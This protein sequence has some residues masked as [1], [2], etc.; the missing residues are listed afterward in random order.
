MGTELKL[1]GYSKDYHYVGKIEGLFIATEQEIDDFLVDRTIDFGEVLGV[2]SDVSLYFK[3]EDFNCIDISNSAVLELLNAVNSRN[4]SGYYPFRYIDQEVECLR[5][6]H[7][8]D[9]YSDWIFDADTI[10]C[11]CC[12]YEYCEVI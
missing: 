6:G 3:K 1:W 8:G 9:Y 4:L 2:H 12:N 10:C 5:C 11:P 7:K